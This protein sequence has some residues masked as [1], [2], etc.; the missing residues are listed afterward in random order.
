MRNRTLLR[1]VEVLCSLIILAAMPSAYAAKQLILNVNDCPSGQDYQWNAANNTLS[2][3]ATS[4]TATPGSCA[5]TADPPSSLESGLPAGTTVSL[6]ASCATGVTPIAFSWNLGNATVS[7]LSVT[8]NPT[9]T[10][11][12]IVTPSNSAGPGSTF[13]TT[14]YIGSTQTGTAPG[15]CSISQSPNTNATAVAAGTNVNLT[16][17]CGTGSPVTCLWSTGATSCSVSVSAPSVNTSYSATASNSSGSA[18]STPTTINVTTAPSAQNFCTGSDQIITVGWP[19]LG[20]V[21]PAT[22]GFGNNTIAFKITVPFTFSPV[23]DISH[24][25]VGRVI[26]VP[27]TPVTSRDFTVS[28]NACDFRSETYLY[29]AIGYGDTAPATNYTVNNPNFFAV[30]GDFNVQSG[31]TFYVNVRNANNGVPSC[32]SASCNVLFDFATPN[33]Y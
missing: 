16:L 14:V 33:R 9:V 3:G 25:G 28:K 13:N 22:S 5:I 20:Q 8:V 18:P 17:S 31:D 12:Y 26:E 2:C 21:R 7:G 23:L 27:G 19:A 6:A 30:G 4:T 11:T 32:P 10:T 29:D 1:V 24:L 15:N